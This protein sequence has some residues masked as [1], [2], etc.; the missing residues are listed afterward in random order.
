MSNWNI[1]RW[2]YLM[3]G[4]I[5]AGEAGGGVDETGLGKHW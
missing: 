4:I 5:W 2:N 3:S 1:Q